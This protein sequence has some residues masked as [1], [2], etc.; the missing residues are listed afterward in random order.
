M[1]LSLYVHVPFCKKKCDYC[2]FVSYAGRESAIDDYLEALSVESAKVSADLQRHE[3][4]TVFI[5][6]GTPTLLEPDR[7]E[8][9]FKTLRSN[10]DFQ[11][12]AEITVEANPGTITRDKLKALRENGVNRISL[13]VQSLDDEMLKKLGRIHRSF[14]VISSVE[15]IREAGFR[16]LGLDLIFAI[17]GQSQKDWIRTLEGAVKLKPEHISTYNLQIE[18]GTPF[19][20]E[21]TEGALRPQSEEAEL[22]MYRTAISKL[23]EA[24]YSHYEISNFAKPGMESRHNIVYWK[25]GDYIGLG[26]GAHSYLN[27]TRIENSSDLS[28]YIKDPVGSKHE[29]RNTKK[30]NM[31]EF[32]FLGLRMMDGFDLEEFT[33]RFGI[34][35]REIYRRELEDLQNDGLLKVAGKKVRLTEKGLYIANEVFKAFL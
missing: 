27:G 29:H 16:N 9:A 3:V 21:M 18:E 10:F 22:D 4:A 28:S 11:S 31:Q 12:G 5:G 19:H 25:M 7:I 26:C 2:D 17:P 15:M 30:E 23:K 32:V 35:F 24:G 13:G 8:K 1:T 34:S 33:G 20:T 6:G 14:E